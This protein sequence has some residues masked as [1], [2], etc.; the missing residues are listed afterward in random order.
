MFTKIP[1]WIWNCLRRNK[2]ELL[3]KL[4]YDLENPAAY[5]G[6]SKL[7]QEAGNHLIMAKG[8]LLKRL[9]YDLKNPAT[10]AVLENLSY[11]KKQR[12]MTQIYQ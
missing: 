7:L 8:E 9:Y 2:K 12:N 4:Y 11:S 6:K 10:Y 3:K 1:N 5:L